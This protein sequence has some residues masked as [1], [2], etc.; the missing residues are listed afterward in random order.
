MTV[1][2][3]KAISMNSMNGTT[4]CL[5]VTLFDDTL[6]E[7]NET[8]TVTLT[9]GT[10]P[11][12]DV[13]LGNALAI[14]TIIDNEGKKQLI[15]TIHALAMFTNILPPHSQIFSCHSFLTIIDNSTR[16][17]GRDRNSVCYFNAKLRHFHS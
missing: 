16:G 4:R 12:A 5:N 14:I 2:M 13:S 7:G 6:V 3:S 15:L 11:G 9:L 10:N 17:W 8:F 1:K